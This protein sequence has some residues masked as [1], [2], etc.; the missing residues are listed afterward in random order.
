MPLIP[1]I[2]DVEAA[3]TRIAPFVWRTPFLKS[4]WLSDLTT[5]EVRLKLEVVQETGAFKVRGAVNAL[6][7]LKEQQPQATTVVTASAGNHG[8]ALAWAARE[9]GLRARVHVPASAPDVKRNGIKRLGAEL[10]DAPSYE[11]AEAQAHEDAATAGAVYISPYNHPDVIAGAGTVALE[12]FED[13]PGLD[14]IV[15]PLGGGG[16]LSGTSIVAR[17]REQAGNPTTLVIGA[18]AEASPVFTTALAHNKI[19]PVEVHQTLADGLAGN[20]EPDSQTFDLVRDLADRVALVSE[21]SIELA[22]RGLFGHERLVAEG[23]AATAVGALLQGRQALAGR[24]IG[25]ILSS[26]NV[27]V[28]VLERVLLK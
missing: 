7:L 24:R 2:T 10:V 20:I 21:S 14:A 26:R 12:M 19:V 9:I 1:T 3:A 5:A 8:L 4:T 16:L 13:W 15:A 6:T 22:M 25:V 27:D 17:A 28:G 18:E 11:A 23:A